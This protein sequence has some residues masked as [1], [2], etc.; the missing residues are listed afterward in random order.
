M[1]TDTV[2][3]PWPLTVTLLPL[4]L[5]PVTFL[6]DITLPDRRYPSIVTVVSPWLVY[7]G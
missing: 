1:L 6:T 5:P 2:A 7:V 4:L 3:V